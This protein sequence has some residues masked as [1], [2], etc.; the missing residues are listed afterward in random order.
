[1][2]VL[3]YDDG[4][5]ARTP[6][7]AEHFSNLG[8]KACYGRVSQQ[9]N[10]PCDFHLSPQAQANV[11]ESGGYYTCPRCRESHDMMEELPWHGTEEAAQGHISGNTRIGLS[12]QEQADI[13]ETL[14]KGLGEIPNYGPITWWHPG[15]SMSPAPLDGATKDWGIEVK[16]LG[17]DATHH[18]FVPGGNRRAGYDEK[19]EK[20]R[21]AI[22]MGKKGVLGVLVLLNYRTSKADIYAREFPVDLTTGVGVAAFRTH[23]ATLI[24]TG[25]PFAN[26]FAQ[27]EHPA[28]H[29]SA[30]QAQEAAIP[31]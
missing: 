8:Y 26:P 22:S 25:I 31:F 13:G 20:D 23:N 6:E 9:N 12:R 28:P 30:F 17:Y 15:G 24:A 21:K 19:A 16:T 29:A 1:M 4:V 5:R 10:I 27:P 18:R 3:S 2:P 7:E 14:I 11:E